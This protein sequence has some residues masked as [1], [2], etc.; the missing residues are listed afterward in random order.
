MVKELVNKGLSSAIWLLEVAFAVFLLFLEGVAHV[1]WTTFP[2]RFFFSF[3]GSKPDPTLDMSFVELVA[4]HGYKAEEHYAQTPDGY[5]LGIHRITPKDPSNV[6]GVVFFQHGFMQN[7]ESFIVRGP[8]KSLPYQ[9]VEAGYDVW[10]GNNR[11]NKYSYKHL[12]YSP[13]DNEFW[14]FCIDDF[15]LSDVPAMLGYVLVS[16]GSKSLSYVGFSQGTAQAFAAFSV[17]HQLAEKV[18]LF[19]A[20]APATRVKQLNNPMVAALTTSRPDLVFLLFGKKALLSE[21][22]FWRRVL[23]SN[24]FILMIDT[25]L[26]FLFGWCAEEL[27]PLEKPILYSHI[28]SYSS[29]KTLVH[30]FQITRMKRFQMFDGHIA[31]RDSRQYPSYLLPSYQLG[32]IKCPIAIFHGG[33]DTIPEIDLLLEEVSEKTFI[34]KEDNY[35]H[36]DFI[37]GT[38]APARVFTKVVHLINQVNSAKGLRQTDE[39]SSIS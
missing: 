7:S 20:L 9:L 21:A 37:W 24:L 26:K 32:K 10:L 15:A 13:K 22:L 8:A 1:L 30:W 6:R 25:C 5:V 29:V 33:K 12:Q 23:P 4:H 36:L 31:P 35:E 28:Y 2:L 34:H 27:D 19:V 18:N 16:T 17:N 38:S 14:D 3:S 11:G 39:L